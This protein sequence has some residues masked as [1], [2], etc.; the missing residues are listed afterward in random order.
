MNSGSEGRVALD[1]LLLDTVM[2]GDCEYHFSYNYPIGFSRDF[3][4]DIGFHKDTLTEYY[5]KPTDE[6]TR[7]LWAHVHKFI[8]FALNYSNSKGKAIRKAFEDVE[9]VEPLFDWRKWIE[10]Q[11]CY[12]MSMLVHDCS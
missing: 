6:M 7:G 9:K 1:P 8:M 3:F 10:W 12:S 5:L 11:V 4:L 2:V